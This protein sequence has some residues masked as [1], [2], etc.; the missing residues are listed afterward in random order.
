MSLNDFWDYLKKR[1][2]NFKSCTTSLQKHLLE[3]QHN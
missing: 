3:L 1:E 2:G